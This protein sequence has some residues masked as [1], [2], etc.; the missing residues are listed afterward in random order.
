MSKAD[1]ELECGW[2]TPDQLKALLEPKLT[3]KQE[4]ILKDLN[5]NMSSSLGR[6]LA[7]PPCGRGAEP[8]R[9][10]KVYTFCW[11]RF[12]WESWLIHYDTDV[13]QRTSQ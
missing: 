9:G 1:C 11:F 3:S 10:T 5:C 12:S 7:E 4:G 8:F 13:V 2:A 6:Q